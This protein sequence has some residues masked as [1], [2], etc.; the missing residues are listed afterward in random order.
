V[1]NLKEEGVKFL[2][3]LSLASETNSVLC[4][5]PTTLSC[6]SHVLNGE[7]RWE[8]MEEEEGE[9]E[10]W[11]KKKKIWS[12]ELLAGW[13]CTIAGEEVGG[14]AMWVSSS[15]VAGVGAVVD[16]VVVDV[17]EEEVLV[18]WVVI[19]ARRDL[20]S[21]FSFL[22]SERHFS[23][24]SMCI[25]NSTFNEDSFAIFCT[26]S[27]FSVINPFVLSSRSV[28]YSFLRCL[29][30]AADCLFFNSLRDGKRAC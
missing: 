27:W 6:E 5:Y 30:R 9:G 7:G 24:E 16:V 29:E 1:Y 17:V 13:V 22:V 19:E 20:N 15:D 12:H 18:C 21:T 2:G 14:E 28:M 4:F 11:K 26:R 25:L 10:N 8:G 3:E 23:S